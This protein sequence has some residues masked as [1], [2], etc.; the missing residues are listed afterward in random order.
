[1]SANLPVHTTVQNVV[2]DPSVF[3]A[4][5]VHRAECLDQTALE[6]PC[7]SFQRGTAVLGRKHLV[8]VQYRYSMRLRHN[9]ET[10][11]RDT[12]SGQAPTTSNTISPAH[13]ARVTTTR[14]SKQTRTLSVLLSLHHYFLSR[15]LLTFPRILPVPCVCVRVSVC[16]SVCLSLSVCRFVCLS[17]CLSVC[18]VCVLCACCVRVV[19]VLC[20]CCVCSDCCWRAC[21]YDWCWFWC[22][23]VLVL[24]LFVLLV[25]QVF[26]LQCPCCSHSCCSGC[27]IFCCSCMFLLL[28]FLLC[29][30]LLL[31]LSLL[32]FL[33]LTLNLFSR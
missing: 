32:M 13:D 3:A 2:T 5:G 12:A 8:T 18:V 31:F 22:A 9:G 19:C 26:L 10:H 33:F 15:F 24:V 23:G 28:L 7:R 6:T 30:Y 21:D 14:P 29:C 11:A 4:W 16:L 27:H 25:L 20:A 1:M 17:V